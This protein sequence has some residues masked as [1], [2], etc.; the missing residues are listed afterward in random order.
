M[1]GP[2]RDSAAVLCVCGGGVGPSDA[3]SVG[4]LGGLGPVLC[5]CALKFPVSYICLD[6]EAPSRC[7]W[8]PH[9][10][11]LFEAAPPVQDSPAT[12]QACRRA[13]SGEPLGFQTGEEEG[14]GQA[15]PSPASIPR[16]PGQGDGGRR[17]YPFPVQLAV[18]S[19]SF[20]SRGP[21]GPCRRGG[22]AP[23]TG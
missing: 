19:P 4:G 3:A 9:Y 22:G 10:A 21:P 7:L 20:L 12:T 1:N 15:G 18:P 8:N 14:R 2:G 17:P 16:G 5:A 6:G 11:S 23:A 13:G